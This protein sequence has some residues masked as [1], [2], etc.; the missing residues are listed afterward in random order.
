MSEP[1][2]S[3]ASAKPRRAFGPVVLLGLAGGALAAVAGN[4][5]WATVSGEKREQFSSLALSVDSGKM[6]A[7]GALALVVLATWGVVLVS[8]GLVRRL[9]AG[10]GLLAALGVLATVV[11]GWSSVG[12][13]LR[14]DLGGVGI[15][16]ASTTHTGWFW[17][18]AVGSVL[19]VVAGALAVRLA[20]QWPEMGSRYDAPGADTPAPAVPV[21]DQTSIDLW[22]AMDEG[23]DPT[24]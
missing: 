11:V 14:R 22:K 2:T 17:A 16:D 4:K 12:D 5:T 20:P 19:A 23:R 24:A 13:T 3:G 9:V 10:L 21:E 7:A 15:T 1:V 8:R 18:A 6:P